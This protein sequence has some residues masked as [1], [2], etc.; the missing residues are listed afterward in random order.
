[1]AEPPQTL[2][3]AGGLRPFGTGGDAA[4]PERRPEAASCRAGPGVLPKAPYLGVDRT[5]QAL[6]TWVAGQSGRRSPL[7]LYVLNRSDDSC[8]PPA[9]QGAV[10]GYLALNALRGPHY[11]D[12]GRQRDQRLR[13][14]LLGYPMKLERPRHRVQFTTIYPCWY[15]RAAT[16]TNPTS[17]PCRTIQRLPH[18][19]QDFHHSH[20]DRRFAERKLL[21]VFSPHQPL[22]RAAAARDKIAHQ[23]E[24][25]P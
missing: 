21:R 1:L 3:R 19:L 2:A 5:R 25:G 10:R 4:A 8:E 23:P 12:Q 6:Q 24:R 15:S 18:H 7:D 11:S 17:R 16:S 13:T 22:Q 14:G 9:P 20:P